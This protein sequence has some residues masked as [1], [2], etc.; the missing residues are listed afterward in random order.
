MNGKPLK[1]EVI[2][3]ATKDVALDQF[4]NHFFNGKE[5]F[6][7]KDSENWLQHMLDLYEDSGLQRFQAIKVSS[8]HSRNAIA[9]LLDNH[10]NC[11]NN[12]NL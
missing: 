11:C 6:Y 5:S 9:L 3:Y 2:I 7:L 4:K 1:V 12:W 8:K 10:I